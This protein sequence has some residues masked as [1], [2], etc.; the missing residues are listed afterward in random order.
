MALTKELPDL[1]SPN[2]EVEFRNNVIHK[3]YVPTDEEATEFGDGV[4]V[5]IS[6]ELERLRRIA[7][8]ALATVYKKLI[9]RNEQTSED[10]IVGGVNILTA[11]DVMHPPK[12]GDERGTTIS[13]H[14]ARVLS[15][16]EPKRLALLSKEEMARRFPDRIKP[17][18]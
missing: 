6:E 2:K 13:T 7:P 9:P 1:L 4:M 18:S 8:D 11:I 15:E 10:E 14:F 12:P 3:G 17:S 5:L 16:R